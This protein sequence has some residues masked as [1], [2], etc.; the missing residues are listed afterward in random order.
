M[1][2]QKV[3][4]YSGEIN[5]IILYCMHNFHALETITAQL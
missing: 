3:I 2:D 5:P 1:T 4:K